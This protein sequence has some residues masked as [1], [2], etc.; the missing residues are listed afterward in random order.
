MVVQLLVKGSSWQKLNSGTTLDIRDI[1]GAQN[2]KGEW[3]ILAIASSSDTKDN[4][5]LQIQSDN[6]I[7][8]LSVSG[9]LP[10]T[11]GIWFV[12]NCNYYVVGNDI[13]QKSSL[14]NPA[15]SNAGFGDVF[16]YASGGISGNN[17]NDVFIVGSN[18][19]V[20]HYNGKSWYNYKNEIPTGYGALMRVAVKGNLAVIVGFVDQQPV[21]IIGRRI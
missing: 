2:C 4:A 19:E 3:E 16:T 11:R 10:F 21:A 9:L 5:L 12:P 18:L 13:G 20:G 15:W 7:K 1:Y 17:T 8:Q 14:N 6:S